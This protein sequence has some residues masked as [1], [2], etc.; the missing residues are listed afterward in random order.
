MKVTQITK[1][2]GKGDQAFGQIAYYLNREFIKNG[3]ETVLITG[4]VSDLPDETTEV[5]LIIPKIFR[6]K[7]EITNPVV[8]R[9]M[10]LLAEPAF[11]IL[12]TIYVMKH[13]G[14][15]G[16]IL[17]HEIGFGGDLM[18]LH[19]CVFQE[20]RLRW[21]SGDRVFALN[22]LFYYRLALEKFRYRLK[23]FK[24]CVAVSNRAKQEIASI[25]KIPSED[26]VTICNGIDIGRFHP[27]DS[28]VSREA[29][30]NMYEIPEDA[31]L[32]LF[33]GHNFWLKGL[34]FVIEALP[35]VKDSYLLVIG[36]GLRRSFET[37]ASERGVLDR[38]RFIGPVT[39]VDKFYVASDLFVF[40]SVYETFSLVCIEAAASGIPVLATKVGGVEDWLRDGY[41]GFFIQRDSND[42]SEKANMVLSDD[43]FKKNL[44]ENAKKTAEKFRWGAVAKQYI[45]LF[46]SV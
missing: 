16:I 46:E 2:V 15:L 21:C 40:P 25:Y 35:M 5:H 1:T 7:Q 19:G 34:K 14:E 24:K 43:V 28:C 4:N 27:E 36:G 22:P 41:N 6:K 3:L 44:G 12:A 20:V 18:M 33:V 10:N 23:K 31:N 26:I 42:I 9:L 38:I 30:R 39:E 29:L 37:L 8:Q 17:D 45:E 32:L 13:K 11:H